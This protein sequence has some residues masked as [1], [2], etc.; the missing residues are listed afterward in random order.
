M[1]GYLCAF[2]F[3]EQT[4]PWDLFVALCQQNVVRSVFFS[5]VMSHSCVWPKASSK[6]KRILA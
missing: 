2:R 5:E 4:A 1:P 3:R 6:S